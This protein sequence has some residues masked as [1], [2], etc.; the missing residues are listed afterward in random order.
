[1]KKRTKIIISVLA[2]VLVLGGFA[3]YFVPMLMLRAAT[4]EILPECKRA[5]YI[6]DFDTMPENSMEVDNGGYT[7]Q[8]PDYL[9]KDDYDKANVYYTESEDA[10]ETDFGAKY[11]MLTE[12]YEFD[13]PMSLVDPSYYEE[14]TT[15]KK[16]G[17]KD[18][19]KMFASLGYGTPDSYYNILKCVCLLDWEDYNILS[20]N[21][22]VA[23]S[24]YAVLRT[25]LYM[26]LDNYIYER[27][28]V[29]AIV[30]YGGEGYFQIDV[31]SADDLDG[32]YGMR[33]NDPDLSFEEVVAMLNSIEFHK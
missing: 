26:N 19:E 10:D 14:D 20:V 15:I 29:R 3:S 16:Y 2:V 22:S 17:I 24:V 8:I 5:E 27:G 4:E 13:E 25:E 9:L 28:G 33:I 32:A 23:F 18:V 12:K 30:Q 11:I 21:K 31:F 6:T 1:M 7:I